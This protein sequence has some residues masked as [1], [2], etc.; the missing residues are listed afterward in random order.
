MTDF[1]E[2]AKKYRILSAEMIMQNGEPEMASDIVTTTERILGC[3]ETATL[4]FPNGNC[5]VFRLHPVL[6]IGSYNLV[7]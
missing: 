3:T 1:I 4:R 2:R 6:K 5:F 7:R